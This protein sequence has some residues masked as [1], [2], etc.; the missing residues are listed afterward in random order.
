MTCNLLEATQ[1][2]DADR[3]GVAFIVLALCKHVIHSVHLN[4]I[5]ICKA[6]MNPFEIFC[7]PF[8]LQKHSTLMRFDTVCF[9]KL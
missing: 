6:K 4:Y 9:I 5:Y 7:K 1:Q 8:S 3:L 2:R